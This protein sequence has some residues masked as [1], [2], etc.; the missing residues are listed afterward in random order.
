DG[1]FSHKDAD[2]I[3]RIG[4]SHKSEQEAVIG[5]FGRGLKSIFHLC[6]GFVFLHSVQVD[7]PEAPVPL[8]G[9]KL[10]TPW[11]GEEGLHRE[12]YDYDEQDETR[13]VSR[14]RPFLPATGRWFCLWIPLRR[15]SGGAL[16]PI[17]PQ[18]D[19]DRITPPQFID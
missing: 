13:L 16:A 14:V 4:Y 5:K 3:V 6:E 18:F 1:P 11:M 19:G 7:S 9:S 2:A 17:A 8:G 12:W 10:F 15:R